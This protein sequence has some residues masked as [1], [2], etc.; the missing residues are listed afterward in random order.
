MSTTTHTPV[1]RNQLE[2]G[3]RYEVDLDGGDEL[4][5]SFVSVLQEI[6]TDTFLFENGVWVRDGGEFWLIED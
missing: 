1:R 3:K 4:F 6:D 5:A 2:V